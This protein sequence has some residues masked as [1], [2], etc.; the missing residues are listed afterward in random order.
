MNFFKGSVQ[1]LNKIKDL[2]AN[3]KQLTALIMR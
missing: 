1:S 3:I 2:E